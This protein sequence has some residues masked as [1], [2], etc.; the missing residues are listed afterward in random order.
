MNW[1]LG[2]R[3]WIGVGWLVVF[4]IFIPGL[5]VAYGP[6]SSIMLMVAI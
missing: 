1:N 3:S 4:L 2:V 5:K 6:P